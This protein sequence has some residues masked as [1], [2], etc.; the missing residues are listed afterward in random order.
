MT[1]THIFLQPQVFPLSRIF[2]GTICVFPYFG[3]LQPELVP[4]GSEGKASACNEGELGSIPGCGR[5]PGEGNGKPCQY[6]CLENPMD[7]G[8]WWAIVHGVAK[9]QTRLNHQHTHTPLTKSAIKS[10]ELCGQRSLVGYSPWGR[11]ES[12][13]TERLTLYLISN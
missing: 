4:R 7:R 6:S 3:I 12:D 13:M 9:S 8:V 10:G 5:S 11:K 2:R 1:F